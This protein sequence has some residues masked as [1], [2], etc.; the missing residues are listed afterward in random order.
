MSYSLVV[1]SI[2]DCKEYY[3]RTFQH[4]ASTYLLFNDSYEDLYDWL[5]KEAVS[6]VVNKVPGK[7]C[8]DHYKHDIYNAIYY[9][10]IGKTIEV[11]VNSK[12]I[13]N[14][15]VIYDNEIIKVLVAGDS[16]IIAKGDL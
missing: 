8:M 14:R 15:I 10:E 13:N 7:R 12:F 5:I 11:M 1:I 9:T 2:A 6:T 3:K 4:L 16:V